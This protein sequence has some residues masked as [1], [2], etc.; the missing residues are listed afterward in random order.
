MKGVENCDK[1][2]EVVKRALIPRYPN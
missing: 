1:L 2:G